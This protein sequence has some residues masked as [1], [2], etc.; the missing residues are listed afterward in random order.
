[1][2]CLHICNDFSLTRVHSNL[3]KA[4]DKNGIS[5]TIFNPVR[6]TTPIGNNSF[7]FATENS[8]IVYSK[9]MNKLHLVYFESKIRFL[10]KD[11]KQKVNL[12]SIDIVHATTL[13]SDG[14]IALK[15]KKNF[16]TPY[17][18]AVRTG[19]INAFLKLRPDLV[20]LALKILK[21][22]SQ[23]IFISDALKKNFF[24]HRL[25]KPH[26]KKLE[27]KCQI[28]YNG[29][30][31]FWLTD[32]APKKQLKPKKVLFVGRMIPTK[33]AYKLGNSI[34]QL[35]EKGFPCEY[36]IVG[37]GGEDEEKVKGLANKNPNT[38]HYHG[39]IRDKDKLKEMF[40][41]CDILGM[42]SIPET[43]GLVYIEALSQGLPVLY[44]ANDGIDGIFSFKVG[45]RCLND[46]Q[47]EITKTLEQLLTTYD[48][49]QL[50]KINFPLFSW[51]NIAPRYIAMY[52]SI[53]NK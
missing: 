41:S 10:Y 18:V 40:R 19:D 39:A 49:C 2:R 8:G 7:D 45:G 24:N 13:F 48:T 53:L 26:A 9:E 36:H 42:P 27:S 33:N 35:N 5:Q 12:E 4:L 29:I 43:F 50:E 17:I 16:N 30:D 25:I 44:C 14:A 21:E 1:M 38:I 37:S 52:S 31:N 3:Y 51:E 6:A 46:T 11:L 20:F 47:N 15:I 23:I 22:A 32:I 34:L 28:L